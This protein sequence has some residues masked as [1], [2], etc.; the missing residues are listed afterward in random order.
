MGEVR[1]VAAKGSWPAEFETLAAELRQ[2]LGSVALQVH[3]VGS[4]AVPWLPA[5]DILDVMVEVA[6]ADGIAQVCKDLAKRGYRVNPIARDHAPPGR[7]DAEQWAKGY[8][9][10]LGDRPVHVHVRVTGRGNVRYALLFRD[11]LRVHPD[12]AMAYGQAKRR[13]GELL[14][15]DSARYAE[16]K[17][18]VCDLIY[19]AAEEWATRTAWQPPAVPA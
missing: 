17:D 5:K 10:L 13:L 11:Y 9:S 18:P 6:D 16:A 1:I 14:P 12:M 8:A 7:E 19:L 2:Q 15:Q 3:H 4:T